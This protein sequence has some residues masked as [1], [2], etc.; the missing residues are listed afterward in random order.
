MGKEFEAKVLLTPDE[1]IS[2]LEQGVDDMLSF[3]TKAIK[4]SDIYYSKYSSTEEAI[5]Y[6]ESLTRIRTEG[7]SAYL[8][9]KKK[10]LI[11]GFENNEEYETRI[12]D[13]E[14]VKKLLLEA[15]YSPYFKKYKTSRT[16][17]V[18]PPPINIPGVKAHIELEK[19]EN[20]MHV[21]KATYKRFYALEIEAVAPGDLDTHTEELAEIVKAYFNYF[22]K[23]E[24][25]FDTR[26]WRNLLG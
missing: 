2:I 24:K 22:N 23:T 20:S 8:T 9:L 15:G 5:K 18:N 12:E 26:S 4:K 6:D 25:D 14:V 7:D 19:V 10:E 17:S 3:V 11:N 1:Y 13:A 16:I 21:E